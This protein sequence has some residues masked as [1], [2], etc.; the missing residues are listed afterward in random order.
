MDINSPRGQKTLE[1]VTDAINIW[2]RNL[3]T[4]EYIHTSPKLPADVD[5][6]L[7]MNGRLAGIVEIKCR[8]SMT[9]REFE[10]RHDSEWLVTFDK[11]ARCMRVADALQ[12]AFVGFLY[13]PRDKILLYKSIYDPV[14]KIV[15]PMRI[16]TSRTQATV[17]GGEIDRS[18]AY[19]DMR[20]AR[21][22]Q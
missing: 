17:N 13:F 15:T 4:I 22:L 5:G 11:V 18:N 14:T 9:F 19:I 2:R 3:P 1:Q 6:L 21:R 20:E 10:N 16:K 12:A 7:V 8:V